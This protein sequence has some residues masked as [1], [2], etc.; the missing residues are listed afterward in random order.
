MGDEVGKGEEKGVK[1]WDEKR[2]RG[3]GGVDRAGSVLLH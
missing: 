1:S 3:L 2:G